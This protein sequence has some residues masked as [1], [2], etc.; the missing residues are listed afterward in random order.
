MAVD[1]RYLKDEDGNIFTPIIS[2]E[3]VYVKKMHSATRM[4]TTKQGE[5]RYIQ[6]GNLI[7][8]FIKDVLLAKDLVNGDVLFQGLPVSNYDMIITLTTAN[9]LSN[10]TKSGLRVNITDG[11]VTVHYSSNNGSFINSGQE[12][13]GVFWYGTPIN[14]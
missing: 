9:D 1:K 3:S 8:G 7:L 4:S 6:F 5:C 11:K 2:S 12:L 14:S 13:N 10:L